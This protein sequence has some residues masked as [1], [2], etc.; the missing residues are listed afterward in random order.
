MRNTTERPESLDA[1]TSRLV[2]TDV[3]RIVASIS[4]LLEDNDIYRKM[5]VAK[6]PYG[7]GGASKR[8]LSA[9]AEYLHV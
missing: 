6:N 8:I 1:G 5:S 2:G 4:E 9:C 7:D 3:E